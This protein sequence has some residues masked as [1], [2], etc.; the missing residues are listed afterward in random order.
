MESSSN[1]GQCQRC[2]QPSNSSNSLNAPSGLTPSSVM[3]ANSNS[4][5][6]DQCKC[7]NEEDAN[8]GNNPNPNL[9][10]HPQQSQPHQMCLLDTRNCR[11]SFLSRSYSKLS[12]NNTTSSAATNVNLATQSN[13]SG[14]NSN[15]NVSSFNSSN[16]N[17]NCNTNN[18]TASG[19]SS[20]GSKSNSPAT[21]FN[22]TPAPINLERNLCAVTHQWTKMLEC[23]EFVGAK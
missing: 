20:S 5:S 2:R 9:N 19:S 3:S 23:A 10:P 12:I 14:S 15:S 17:F 16:S 18:S 21:Y 13:N 8:T 6:L 7:S 1:G 22:C 4:N 11:R